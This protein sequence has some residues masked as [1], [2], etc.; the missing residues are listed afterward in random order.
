MSCRFDP[1]A[2]GNVGRGRRPV[3][4]KKGSWVYVYFKL[5][6]NVIALLYRLVHVFWNDDANAANL[7]LPLLSSFLVSEAGRHAGVKCSISF[8]LNIFFVTRVYV[9]VYVHTYIMK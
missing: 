7:I 5:N 8:L 4:C 3:H 2:V 1:A 6:L 9:Y